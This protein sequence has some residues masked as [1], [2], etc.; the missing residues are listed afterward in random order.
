MR[1]EI[2]VEWAGYPWVI[3]VANKEL[4]ILNDLENV[5]Y[6]KLSELVKKYGRY[7]YYLIHEMKR[8]KLINVSQDKKITITDLGIRVLNLARIGIS[9]KNLEK[10]K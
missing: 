6:I 2:T 3:Y 10:N 7:A 4:N 5:E 8:K 9:V 1:Y